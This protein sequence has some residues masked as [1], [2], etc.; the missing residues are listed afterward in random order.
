MKIIDQTTNYHEVQ[1][2][3]QSHLPMT[4]PP[5]GISSLVDYL[6]PPPSHVWKTFLTSHTGFNIFQGSKPVG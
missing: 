4:P 1:V 2:L 5:P 3:H 6:V